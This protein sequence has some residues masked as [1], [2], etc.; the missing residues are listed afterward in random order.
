ML[1]AARAISDLGSAKLV[2]EIAVVFDRRDLS[3]GKISKSNGG[4]SQHRERNMAPSLRYRIACGF[5]HR[6]LVVVVRD[7]YQ[8][9]I[10]DAYVGNSTQFRY[11]SLPA[12]IARLPDPQLCRAFFHIVEF[13]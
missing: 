6:F 12:L 1:I 10:V 3:R 4:R 8:V 9:V 13:P 11:K 5:H 2:F 7:I